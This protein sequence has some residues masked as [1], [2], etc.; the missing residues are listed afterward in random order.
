MW[1]LL[2]RF[3]M[4]KRIIG[5]LNSM[6]FRHIFNYTASHTNHISQAL[7]KRLNVNLDLAFSKRWHMSSSLFPRISL[8]LEE[9]ACDLMLTFIFL[10]VIYDLRVKKKWEKNEKDGVVKMVSGRFEQLAAQSERSKS[11][12]FKWFWNRSFVRAIHL[13]RVREGL[14]GGKQTQFGHL[15]KSIQHIV[16]I[17]EEVNICKRFSRWNFK[18]WSQIDSFKL[19]PDWKT[20][21][22]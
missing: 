14:F 21:F 19:N 20:I 8:Q 12:R 1:F 9:S 10:V 13:M 15:C 11:E 5:E 7:R 18:C 6:H 4:E 3:A 2:K 22:L 17:R 16:N